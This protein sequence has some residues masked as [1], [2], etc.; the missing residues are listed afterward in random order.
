M[1]RIPSQVPSAVSRLLQGQVISSPPTWYIPALSHPPPQLP[2]YQVKSRPRISNNPGVTGPGA[3]AGA[4]PGQFID[5]APIPAGELER[6]DR[7][8]G[9]K[10]RKG[11][12]LK[13][14]YEE[15][16]VRRQFF[17]D[18]PFEALRPVSMVE[19]GEID[20]REKVAG[21]KWTS[22]EQRGLYPTVEDCI[23][24]VINLRNTRD[25]SISEA[26]ALATEEFVSLRGRH[27]L[28]T[29][30]AEMEGRHYGAEYKPDV[31]ERAFNLE[32][33][34]LESLR[35]LSASSSSSS[36][37]SSRVKYRE[38]PRWQWSNTVPSSSIP[39]AAAGGGGGFSAGQNYVSKWKMPEPLRVGA[40][41]KGDLLAAIPR[42]AAGEEEEKMTARQVLAEE[43]DDKLEDLEM[44]KA[45]L[46][47]SKS[48]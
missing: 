12:P 48:A 17:K 35:P 18:F 29:L 4:K 40:E 23:E 7:L 9:Y 42:A 28:A 21:E 2:P 22:L 8:R 20:V 3:G 37:S 44:L 46:G 32:E 47:S 39:G 19:G 1:R 6:R 36:A 15:D 38:Q 33:K 16:R 30:A 25:L 41:G 5:T 43:E 24:F 11:R 45:A 34:A 26:Y 31:F 27:Q 10:Q 14:A 13:V